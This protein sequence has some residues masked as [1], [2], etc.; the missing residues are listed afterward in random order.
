M[1][2]LI[3]SLI[4]IIPMLLPFFLI[5]LAPYIRKKIDGDKKEEKMK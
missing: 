1:E 2:T 3:I 4:V 5:I